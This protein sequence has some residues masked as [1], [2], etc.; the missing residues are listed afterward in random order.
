[1]STSV[2][3]SVQNCPLCRGTSSNL[4]D[5]RTFR[6]ALVSNRVC[7]GCGLVYQSPRMSDE[8]LE[9]FYEQ[10][11]R[12]LYQNS[13]EPSPKDLAVQ[14]GRARSLL[15][16]FINGIQSALN[17]QR[18]TPSRHLDIGCSAGLLLQGFQTEYHCESVGIEPGDAYRAYAQAQGL[19]VHATLDT[20]SQLDLP[21][22]LNVERSMPNGKFDLISL[23]HVLEHIPN[24]VEYLA[25]LRQEWL[26]ADGWLLVEV[27]NL[28]GHDCFEI[29]HLTSFSPHTL[30][31]TLQQAGFRIQALETHGRPRSELIPLY[32]TALARPDE[33]S[34]PADPVVDRR[35]TSAELIRPENGVRRKRKVAMF[36]SKI[37]TRLFPRKAWLPV[38]DIIS[39]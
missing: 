2:S 15:S 19:E 6:D 30:E 23:A 34:V 37:V 10:E 33:S 24:P 28:Y 31:Q 13:Q 25:A 35:A 12:Q 8:D 4:F 11:Y 39:V 36:R 5:Q 27:P 21:Q 16:F 3:I 32:I 1:M 26:T 38:V 18:S 9:A 22:T 14:A 17:I 29:A 20:Y 7:L